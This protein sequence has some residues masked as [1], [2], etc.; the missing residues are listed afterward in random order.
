MKTIYSILFTALV[1]LSACN[2]QKSTNKEITLG[3]TIQTAGGLKYFYLKKGEGRKVET[4]C[5]VGAY[6]SLQVDGKVVWNTNE[7]PDSLFTYVAD[8]SRLIKGFKEV[9]MLLREGDEVVAILPDSLAY[10]SRGAGDVI[11]PNATLVYDQFKVIQVE[12]PK[13]FLSDLLYADMNEKSLEDA[14]ATYQ[15]IAGGEEANQ[16]HTDSEQ[17]NRVWELLTKDNLHE[18]AANYATKIGE[19]AKDDRLKYRNVL[20]LESME[21]YLAAKDHLEI[22]LKSD[23]E[24]KMMQEKMIELCKKHSNNR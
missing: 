14:I 6:L 15:R 23:P 10:G 18:K 12:A 1:M 20:S 4:G 11:P 17:L 22:L 13:K 8:Y 7:L 9:S 5:K 16:Y 24:N 2:N 3:D 19:L 21:D